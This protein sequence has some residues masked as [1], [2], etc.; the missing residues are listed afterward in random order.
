MKI[1]KANNGT[2]YGQFEQKLHVLIST[3][4]L[5]KRHTNML[6]YVNTVSTIS[7]TGPQYNKY[8]TR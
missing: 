6:T 1:G 4:F 2:K 5:E 7:P 3:D 8:G